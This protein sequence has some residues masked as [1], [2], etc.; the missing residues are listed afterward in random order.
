MNRQTLSSQWRRLPHPL[1]W[2]GV[3]IVGGALVVTGLVLMVLPG[4]GIPLLVLGLVILATEF[5]WAEAVLSRV[6]KQG[7]ALASG[8][9][10]RIGRK[11]GRTQ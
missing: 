9:S 7:S 3:A 8:V 2:L 5:A 4:P 6:K 10:K 11:G 1:R